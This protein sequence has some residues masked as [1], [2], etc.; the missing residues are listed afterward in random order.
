MNSISG[1]LQAYPHLTFSRQWKLSARASYAL[2]EC[3]AIVRSI[4]QSPL[5]PHFRNELHL[6]SLRKGAQATTA[7][8]GNTL[9][10]VEI[11]AILNGRGNATEKEYQQREVQNVLDAF[12]TLLQEVIVEHRTPLITPELLLRFH[13]MIGRE[14]GHHFAATPGKFARST[15]VVGPYKA[16]SHSDV[17]E[18]V[19]RLSTWLRDEFHYPNQTLGDAIVQAIVTHVYIEWIHPFDDGNGRTGR[20]V[21]FYILLRAG[22]PSIASH[23]LANHYNETRSEYYR[24]LQTCRLEQDLS[25]FIEYAILGLRSGL[26]RTLETVQRNALEQM[27]RVLVYDTFK[28]RPIKNR[29]VFK[30]QREV[31]LELPLDRPIRFE[32]VASLSEELTV[33]YRGSTLRT[34]LRDLAVL[35]S[36]Q[37]LVREP[38]LVRA[39]RERLEQTIPNKLKKALR[40]T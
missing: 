39:N 8:E 21:E 37:L 2:G 7:I 30:R 14:L 17:P 6:L 4:S 11:E 32:E 35:E 19:S 26:Q 25:G 20:L 18:L 23:L 24:Q 13:E 16:P 28:S 1:K 38:G 36:M 40:A 27:W 31:A 22:L 33:A 10:E 34:V 15:R 9:S 3:D 29:G 5:L 12:N